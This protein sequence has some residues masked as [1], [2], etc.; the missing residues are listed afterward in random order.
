MDWDEVIMDKTSMVLI[1]K[2]ASVMQSIPENSVA[3]VK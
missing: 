2:H 1:I 3:Q